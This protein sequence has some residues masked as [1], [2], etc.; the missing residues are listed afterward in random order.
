MPRSAIVSDL[1]GNLAALEAVIDELE[2]ERPDVVVHGGDLALS[3]AHP[4]E[5][6]DRVRELG[7]P[8]VVGNVDELLWRPEQREARE[9]EAPHRRPLFRLLFGSHA[10]AT[11]EMLGRQRI[12]WLRTLP[13]E[14][15]IGEVLVMHASPRALWQAPLARASD[16]ELRETYAGLGAALVVYGH[17]HR[18]FV[19]TLS[20]LIVANSGSVGQPWDGDPRT[21]YLVIED[22]NVSIRRVEYDVER[23]AAAL[24]GRGYPDAQWLAERLRLGRFLPVPER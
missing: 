21:S 7:W 24:L 22:G 1:H 23:E 10:D 13:R 9:A 12:G 11:R 6:V 2:C 14:H 4:A 18:P 8:G 5:V 3:G 15:R 17:I 20:D 19:R 16:E